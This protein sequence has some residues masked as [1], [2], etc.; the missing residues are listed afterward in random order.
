MYF[1]VTGAAGGIGRAVS[2]R[3]AENN[4]AGLLLVDCDQA[5]LDDAAS[6]VG[7]E[8]PKI[9]ALTI[10][11]ADP[12]AGD[13]AIEAFERAFPRLTGVVSNAGVVTGGELSTT[14][15]E[16]FDRVI[17]VNLRATFLL[18]KA[19]RR[20][21]AATNG[22]LVAV[23]SIS[24]EHSVPNVGAY[25]ASKAGLAAM[26]RQLALEWAP[27][28]VR[29]NCVAPGTT[30]TGMTAQGL[31][32]PNVRASREQSIPAARVGAPEDIAAVVAFLLSEDAAF[33][34][35]VNWAVDGGQAIS[36]FHNKAG[37]VRR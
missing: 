2:R 13:A 35:G 16:E 21:L 23:S 19:A 18:A 32:D 34:N 5:R 12:S 22:S 15:V 10:D 37:A 26:C 3:L 28:G 7:G 25:S 31:A 6:A 17:A 14:S 24:A 8:G 20:L 36:L 33:V 27:D 4:A 29:V 1:I 30:E 9:A 11:L